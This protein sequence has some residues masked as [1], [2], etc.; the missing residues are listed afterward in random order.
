M[1]FAPFRVFR[2]WPSYFFPMQYRFFSPRMKIWPWLMAMEAWHFSL[3]GF[4]ASTLK[5]EPTLMT[6]VSPS[7]LRK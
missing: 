2:G 1:A 5:T 6:V 3:S 4:F 7:S